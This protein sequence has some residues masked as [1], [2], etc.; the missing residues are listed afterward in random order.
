MNAAELDLDADLQ[1]SMA[2]DWVLLRAELAGRG[3]DLPDGK[4]L[5]TVFDSGYTRGIRWEL[6]VIQ[7]TRD[8]LGEAT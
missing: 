8:S 4:L 6:R 2:A 3:V 1:A 5:R 7:R